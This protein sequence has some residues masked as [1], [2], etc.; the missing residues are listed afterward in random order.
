VSATPSGMPVAVF[1]TNQS[2]YTNSM[3]RISSSRFGGL[4]RPAML[5]PYFRNPPRLQGLLDWRQRQ[6]QE[7]RREGQVGYEVPSGICDLGRLVGQGARPTGKARADVCPSDFR[8]APRVGLRGAGVEGTSSINSMTYNRAE[9]RRLRRQ[10]VLAS[11][12]TQ[13]ECPDLAFKLH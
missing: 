8:A 13:P 4:L 5:V 2:R 10:V 9:V 3:G 6:L 11:P 7:H 1:Q 12:S